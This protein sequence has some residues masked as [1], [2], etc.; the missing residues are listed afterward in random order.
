M[1]KRDLLKPRN[2]IFPEEY[3]EALFFVDAINKSYWVSSKW[4]FL[5]DKHDFDTRCTQIERGVTKR[6]MLCVSNVEVKI[7]NFW[8]LIFAVFPKSEFNSLGITMAESEVRHE[9]GYRKSL[10]VFGLVQEFEDILNVPEI[11]NRLG[12]LEKY[13]KF[14][15]EDGSIDIQKFLIA[16]I[17]FTLIIENTSLFSQFLIMKTINEKRKFFKDIDNL[18]LDT[19]KEENI[20]AMVGA[21]LVNTLREEHPEFFTEDLNKLI[22]ASIKKAYIAE[23]NIIKWIF[24]DGELD[25]LKIWEVDNYI[26][27]RFNKSLKMINLQPIFDDVDYKALDKFEF[28]EVEQNSTVLVDFFQYKNPNYSKYRVKDDMFDDDDD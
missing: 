8:T 22:Y 6:T 13:M 1:K 18:I 23:S 14:R 25:Y 15:N 27:D 10:E 19:T 9:R 12:Y 20:H 24:K 16:L 5:T 28:F 2:T 26:K 11:K 4:S 21:W 3:P 17:L 7:K